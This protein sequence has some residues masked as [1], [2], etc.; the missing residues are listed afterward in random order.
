MKAAE[1]CRT[2]RRFAFNEENFVSCG[3]DWFTSVHGPFSRAAA[4]FGSIFLNNSNAKRF[5]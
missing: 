1:G 5:Y 2:P 3:S 4:T